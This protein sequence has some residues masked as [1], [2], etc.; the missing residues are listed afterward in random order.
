MISNRITANEAR[1]FIDYDN[2]ISVSPPRHLK[3]CPMNH[4]EE[5]IDGTFNKVFYD[6]N[7]NINDSNE[8]IENDTL[9]YYTS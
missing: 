3:Y 5:N 2:N 8:P 9:Y 6:F 1:A 4:I 7:A